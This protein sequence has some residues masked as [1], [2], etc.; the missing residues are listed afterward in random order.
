MGF[1]KSTA[2]LGLRYVFLAAL[3]GYHWLAKVW[4]ALFVPFEPIRSAA[5]RV[6]A[7][8]ISIGGIVSTLKRLAFILVLV[9]ATLIKSLIDRVMQPV[10]NVVEN[11]SDFVERHTPQQ[12]LEKVD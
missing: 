5:N 2:Y 4:H 12:R 10:H 1:V 7:K 9:W 11:M 8:E 6:P 3:L